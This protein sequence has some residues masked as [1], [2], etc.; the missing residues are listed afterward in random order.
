MEERINQCKIWK[1]YVTITMQGRRILHTQKNTFI[2]IYGSHWYLM[3]YDSHVITVPR[4]ACS[5]SSEWEAKAIACQEMWEINGFER[6]SR[7]VKSKGGTFGNCGHGG[8]SSRSCNVSLDRDNAI[9]FCGLRGTTGSYYI[10]QLSFINHII[11][12]IIKTCNMIKHN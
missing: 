12:R 11:K 5:R 3:I 9:Q 6:V 8:D 4:C 2:K 7:R 10:R 1:Q